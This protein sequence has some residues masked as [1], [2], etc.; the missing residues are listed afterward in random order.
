MRICVTG[1]GLLPLVQVSCRSAVALAQAPAKLHL[2]DCQH[3]TGSADRG[4]KYLW[5]A[6]RRLLQQCTAGGA[7]VWAIL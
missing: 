2:M 7:E 5:Q 1:S 3:A 6:S 4:Y